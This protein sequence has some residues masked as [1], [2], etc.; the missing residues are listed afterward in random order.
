MRQFIEL[1]AGWRKAPMSYAERS[2]IMNSINNKYRTAY[3]AE[4]AA[5]GFLAGIGQKRL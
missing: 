3:S 1:A 5:V 2:K 4:P